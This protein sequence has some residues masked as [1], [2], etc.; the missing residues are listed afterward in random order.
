M[1]LLVKIIL[2]VV[3][4]EVLGSAGALTMG[5]AL[6][7]WYPNLSKPPGTPPPWVFG[8]V[9]GTL[10]AMIGIA[11]ALVWHRGEPGC[12]KRSALLWFGVQMALNVAWTPLFFGLRQV[13]LA[14]V[15][16]VVLWVVIGV[17]IQRFRR[18]DRLAAALLIPYLAWVS[19]ATWLNAGYWWLNR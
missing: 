18:V 9:W 15:V 17:T 1:G 16:I 7:E 6:K 4:V 12:A 14:L 13:A 11:L 8:P 3:A 10:Y 2:C 5:D 19:Y